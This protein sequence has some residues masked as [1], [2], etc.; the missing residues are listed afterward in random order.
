VLVLIG[1]SPKCDKS[2]QRRGYWSLNTHYGVN[3]A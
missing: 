1:L 2:A 3:F